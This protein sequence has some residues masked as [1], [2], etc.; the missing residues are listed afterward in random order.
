MNRFRCERDICLFWT[1]YCFNP[2]D[3]IAFD[4]REIDGF[5]FRVVKVSLW[6]KRADVSEQLMKRSRH[7]SQWDRNSLIMSRLLSCLITDTCC[8]LIII[9]RSV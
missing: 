4:L 8:F 9:F 2:T 7:G 3:S 1:I 5:F 6:F